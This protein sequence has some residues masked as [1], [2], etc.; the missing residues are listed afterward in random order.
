M[1]QKMNEHDW[2]ALLPAGT[3]YNPLSIAEALFMMTD[4]EYGLQRFENSLFQDNGIWHSSFFDSSFSSRNRDDSLEEFLTQSRLIHE[5]LSEG[6]QLVVTFGTSICY[7]SLIEKKVV[8]NC[9]KQPQTFFSRRRVN[10]NEIFMIWGKV[11]AML[12]ERYPGIKT[13]FTVSP[14]RH[15]KDGFEGN[16]RS[17]AV[18]LLSI[19][20]IVVNNPDSRYFPAFEIVTDDLRDYRFYAD[21]LVHPSSQ[22]VDYI[23][24]KFVETFIDSK[25]KK[26]LEEGLKKH[27]TLHHR[28]LLG[29]LSRPL[30]ETNDEK[31]EKLIVD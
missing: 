15:L 20:D 25:G 5:K 24:E 7:F 21:D 10:T 16:A 17:K 28:P 30:S 18:L 9:H 26:L 6:G 13:I 2:E 8:G 4:S 31:D 19:E 29:A 3:L 22:A 11:L 23:W 27:K 12:R 1:A 14:V